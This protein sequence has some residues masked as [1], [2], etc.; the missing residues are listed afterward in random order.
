MLSRI[1]DSMYWLSRYMERIES[2]LRLTTIHYNLSLDQGLTSNISW[3]PT[4]ELFT[5]LSPEEIEL[6]QHN[7]N[8]ALN[9]LI[10]DAANANSIKSLIN[11]ARENARGVQ[12]H[13]TKEVWAQVNQMYHLTNQPHIAKKLASY[14]AP[15]IMERLTDQTVLYAGITNITMPRGEPWEFMN[16]G[17]Y[18]ERCYQTITITEKELDQ[19]NL[20]DPELNHIIQW[21]YLLLSLSGYELHLKT[22]RTAQHSENA[23]HQVVFNEHFAHSVLYSLHH[24]HIYLKM[25]MNRTSFSGSSEILRSFGKL[26]SKVKYCD[27][28]IL[29]DGSLKPFLHEVKTDLSNFSML[30]SQQYFSYA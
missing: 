27:P 25:I 2:L 24:F 14:E 20:S 1:A 22:Y 21:R 3:K 7:T 9:K 17:K 5:S 28:Q 4:L 30:F 23:L 13:L 26:Y 29:K 6:E 15:E 19:K 16:L 11:K 10:I 18:F 12:D 8:A